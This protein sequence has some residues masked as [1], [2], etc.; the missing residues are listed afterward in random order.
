MTRKLEKTAQ[1]RGVGIDPPEVEG[2]QHPMVLTVEETE[3][4]TGRCMGINTIGG[5]GWE[6]GDFF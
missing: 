2:R 1:G 5:E 3:R 6:S 4:V